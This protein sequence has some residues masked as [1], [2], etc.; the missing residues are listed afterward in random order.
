MKGNELA[1][2]SIYVFDKYMEL[3]VNI[4]R[5]GNRDLFRVPSTSKS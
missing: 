3:P 5:L 2:N 4:S 1:P